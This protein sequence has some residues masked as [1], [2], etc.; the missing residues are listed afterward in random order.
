MALDILTECR[1]LS[2]TSPG[3][4]WPPLWAKAQERVKFTLK[5]AILER[6]GLS[7]PAIAERLNVSTGEVKLARDELAEV[8]AEQG[9]NG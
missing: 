3:R 6:A 5:V 9:D 7:T 1:G 4:L 2:R 8:R